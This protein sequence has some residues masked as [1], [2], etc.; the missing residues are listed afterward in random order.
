MRIRSD[1]LLAPYIDVYIGDHKAVNVEAFDT[2]ARR[3]LF[4]SGRTTVGDF[5][6]ELKAEAPAWARDI[7]ETLVDL[8]ERVGLGRISDICRRYNMISAG[9]TPDPGFWRADIERLLYMALVSL[10]RP[11]P[12]RAK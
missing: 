9:E 7:Y 8:D 12:L 11:E 6:I 5:R 1:H 4:T 2:D 3:I 10:D